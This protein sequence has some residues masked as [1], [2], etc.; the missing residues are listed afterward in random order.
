MRSTRPSRLARKTYKALCDKGEKPT[1]R[2]VIDA[3]KDYDDKQEFKNTVEEIDSE[4]ELVRGSRL[5][6]SNTRRS[7]S[8]TPIRVVL[9][10]DSGRYSLAI[11][12]RKGSSSIA[13]G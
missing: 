11:M 9:A 12:I 2:Q 7:S 5:S 3:L 1:Y 13:A 6:L 10:P 4:N 8:A